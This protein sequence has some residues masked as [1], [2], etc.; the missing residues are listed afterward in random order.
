M[1]GTQTLTSLIGEVSDRIITAIATGEF[2]VGARLPNERDLSQSLGVGRTSTRA[3][4]EVLFERGLIVTRR[5]RSGGSFVHTQR[6]QDLSAAVLRYLPSRWPQTRGRLEASRYLYGAVAHAAANAREDSDVALLEFRLGAYHSAPSG[7]LKQAA[8]ADLQLAIVHSAR[9]ETL[10]A[11]LYDL[12]QQTS[13]AAPKRIWGDPDGMTAREDRI[14]RDHTRLVAAISGK[15]ASEAEDLARKH[16]QLD[17]EL[18]QQALQRA[19][20]SSNLT[21]S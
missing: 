12:K 5:G 9:N 7:S 15:H 2:P 21:A 20:D 11:L 10:Q 4:L 3:A 16:G 19:E 13:I 6:P 17:L 1:A 8:E 14:A 18:F